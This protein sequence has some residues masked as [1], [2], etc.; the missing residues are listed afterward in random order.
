MVFRPADRWVWDF[1]LVADQGL[2]HMFYLH[3]PQT[4]NDPDQRH[5]SASIGHAVSRD[6]RSWGEQS[7]ALRPGA[8]GAWDDMATWTGSVVA[9]LRGGWAMLYTG[10]AT[11]MVQRAC[12][13]FGAMRPIE[14]RGPSDE[15]RQTVRVT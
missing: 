12:R 11:G 7:I 2:W 3:A 13:R 6:L 5:F 15:T 8:L 10:I 4:P 1:W 14:G 9:D